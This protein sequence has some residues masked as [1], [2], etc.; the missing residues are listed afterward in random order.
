MGI[1]TLA[2]VCAVS[3]LGSS[4][5]VMRVD[6]ANEPPRVQ[7]RGLVDGHVALGLRDEDQIL[8]LRA[9]DGSSPGSLLEFSVWKLFRLEV[10]LLGAGVGIG[11]VDAALGVAFYEPRVPRMGSHDTEESWTSDDCPECRAARGEAPTED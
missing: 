3:L 5:T 6:S 2:A 4:C 1:R 10:G 7:S 11:P 9:L 8:R